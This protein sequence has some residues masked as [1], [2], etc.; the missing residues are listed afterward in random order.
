M[1]AYNEAD[2]L[3][4]ANIE[5]KNEYHITPLDVSKTDSVIQMKAKQNKN[6]M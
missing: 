1:Y 5:F 3:L 4:N 6:S 2:F